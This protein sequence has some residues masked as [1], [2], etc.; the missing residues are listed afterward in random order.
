MRKIDKMRKIRFGVFELRW[1]AS[2]SRA[3]SGSDGQLSKT[4]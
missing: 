3:Q 4:F 2:T 1:A